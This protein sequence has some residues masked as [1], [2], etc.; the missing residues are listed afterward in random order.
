MARIKTPRW[1]GPAAWGAREARAGDRLPYAAH[2]SNSLV[3]LRDG[4][5]LATL[6]IAGLPFETEDAG[7]LDHMLAVRDTMLRS[8]LDAR[9]ILY[10]HVVRRRVAVRLPAEFPEPFSATI[11]T[12]R[13]DRLAR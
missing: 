3:A 4:A 1:K 5:V 12:A 13:Q 8:V 9:F 7:Q 2:V 11:D 6:R 10:H